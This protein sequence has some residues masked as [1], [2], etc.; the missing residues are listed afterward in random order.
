MIPPQPFKFKCPKC[1]YT[2]VVK[3]KSDVLNP[4][5]MNNICHKCKAEMDKVE[6]N[7]F[8]KIFK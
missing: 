5:D 8:D 2:K 7:I 1:R 4:M 6:L 3:P